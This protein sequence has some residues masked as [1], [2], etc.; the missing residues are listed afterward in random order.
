M[1]KEGVSKKSKDILSVGT[2]G[3]FLT[4]AL[5][6]QE[7]DE[8]VLNNLMLCVPLLSV[9]LA[10][11]LAWFYQNFKDSPDKIVA[12]FTLK[13]RRKN[14]ENELKNPNLSEIV[15]KKLQKKLDDV[16]LLLSEIH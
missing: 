10:A 12:K 13:R 11:I 3:A 8:K 14:L 6:M 15:R 1:N 16:I 5:Q 9:V 4:D 7:L 2:V